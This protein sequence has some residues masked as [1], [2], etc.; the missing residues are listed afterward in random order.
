MLILQILFIFHIIKQRNCLNIL[1]DNIILNNNINDNNLIITPGIIE[2]KYLYKRVTPFTLFFSNNVNYTYD[3]II[4]F[5]SINCLID[6]NI[7]NK[8]N[9]S[10]IGKALPNLI[11]HDKDTFSLRINKKEIN[12]TLINIE[13]LNNDF[14][15]NYNR[16]C[17]LIINSIK[18]SNSFILSANEKEPIYLNFNESFNLLNIL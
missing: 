1:E 8:S 10:D 15:Y 18:I 16:T 3:L 17:P 7:Y 13:P 2:T 9:K 6:I 4:N 12:N 5:H 14:F 11:G